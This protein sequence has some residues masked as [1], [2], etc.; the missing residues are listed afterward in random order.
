MRGPDCLPL[1]LL[2]TPTT[3]FLVCGCRG[4]HRHD[5]HQL[6]RPSSLPS[7]TR[8]KSLAQ[9]S[10]MNAWQSA[11]SRLLLIF[12]H[13]YLF[14]SIVVLK[15]MFEFNSILMVRIYIYHDFK[16]N[17]VEFELKNAKLFVKCFH[18]RQRVK[19]YVS[20]KHVC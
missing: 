9:C 16:S 20:L 15:H 1:A 12:I 19:C 7:L 13:G 17:L 4:C 3:V 2:S 11:R 8:S 6:C 18:D 10:T 14:V 5:H